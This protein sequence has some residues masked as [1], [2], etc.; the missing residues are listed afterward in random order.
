[1]SSACE[2]SVLLSAF[3][4]NYTC[5]HTDPSMA[6]HQDTCSPASPVSQTWH[7]DNDCGHLPPITWP[8]RACVSLQS[9]SRRSRFPALQCGTVFRLT[10]HQRHHSQFSDSA[11]SRSCSVSLI[12]TFILLL[13]ILILC[14]AGDADV[15]HSGQDLAD[16]E[17]DGV[18]YSY[19]FFHFIFFLASLYIMM[20]LTHWYR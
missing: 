10:S 1:M 11:S 15:E 20:T 12:R 6:Q 17:A 4:L 8:C 19:S 13:L 3:P 2:Y 9:A 18:A 5:W 14:T 16:D 7:L